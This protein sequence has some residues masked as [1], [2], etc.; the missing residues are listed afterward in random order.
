MTRSRMGSARQ[1]ARGVP[2]NNGGYCHYHTVSRV[3]SPAET[4]HFLRVRAE[5]LP[6]RKE[7]PSTART[8]PMRPIGR[9]GALVRTDGEPEPTVPSRPSEPIP[10]LY[11]ASAPLCCPA[12]TVTYLPRLPCLSRRRAPFAPR[13]LHKSSN[14]SSGA[15]AD[16]KRIPL[17]AD[18]CL[19]PSF[20]AAAAWPASA[21]ATSQ[22]QTRPD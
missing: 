20:I 4:K 19:V 21:C 12:G 3:S 7:I 13:P 9:P 1:P 16:R 17:P 22:D 5:D 11:R 15:C 8:K 2:R 10:F 14:Y 6:P 18:C